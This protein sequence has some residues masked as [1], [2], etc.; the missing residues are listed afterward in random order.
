MSTNLDQ[1]TGSCT[2][3]PDE[4]PIPC[5]RKYALSECRAADPRATALTDLARITEEMG[6]Y[7][8]GR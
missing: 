2:C 4:A 5:P 1:T 7:E 6:L 8:N 3:P